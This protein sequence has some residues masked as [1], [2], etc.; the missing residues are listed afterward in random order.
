[1]DDD[2]NYDSDKNNIEMQGGFK[3]RERTTR[4]EIDID[5]YVNMIGETR[6]KLFR[7]D[8][9]IFITDVVRIS[10]ELIDLGILSDKDQDTILEKMN[11]L[12]RPEFKNATA[13]ILGY[14]VSDGGSELY[15]DRYYIALTLIGKTIKDE[16]IKKISNQ[17]IR[18]KIFYIKRNK[19][20]VEDS[21][22]QSPDIIRYGRLW[23]N[24]Y[25]NL[26]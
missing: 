10:K 11:S 15:K 24:M 1:M 8:I 13:Y 19:Y 17:N 22:V 20:T 14:I 12:E 5:V 9:E 16:K 4:R 23:L 18:N 25:G 2:N 3:D 21:S 26:E 6:T 7:S